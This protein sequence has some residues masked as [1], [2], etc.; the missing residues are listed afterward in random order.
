MAEPESAA[1]EQADE[2]VARMEA[3]AVR[4]MVLKRDTKKADRA[5][6]QAG[7]R[8]Q[9]DFAEA[10][11]RGI[12]QVRP[13]LGDGSEPG[14]FVLL[15]GGSTVAVDEDLLMSVIAV[16]S[17]A[18]LEDYAEAAALRDERVV[19]LIADHFP[20]FVKV[21]IKPEV[22]ARLQVQIEEKNGSIA[23]PATGELVKVATITHHD[24]T[25]TFQFRPGARFEQDI[26]AAIEAGQLTE[27]GAVVAPG[28][29]AE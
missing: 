22:R 7:Q 24:P 26:A 4:M 23:D 17:A 15:G 29:E 28:S 16:S 19:K 12:T 9:A 2:L 11:R 27:D 18:D 20:E 25:G 10:R 13:K 5:F 21:R 1:P 8:A 6:D 3:A 14:L